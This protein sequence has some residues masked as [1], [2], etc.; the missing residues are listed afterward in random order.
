MCSKNKYRITQTLLSNWL[1]VY[2]TD[3]GYEKFIKCLNRIKE[4]PTQQMLDG[5]QFENCVNSVLDGALIPD[6]HKWYKPVIEI[7][8]FLDRSQKQ[9]NL[10]KDITV[11]G[12][13]FLLHGV[14]DF[15]KAGII[16]DTKFSKTYKVGNYR[17]SPQTPMYFS[18]VPEAYKFIYVICDGKYIYKE[19]YS[20]DDVIPIE[21]MI[22]DFMRFLD[23]YNLVDTYCEKWKVR[24]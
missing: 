12:V 10:F 1:F 11:D 14:L 3:N 24:N 6:D 18:L 20:R 2:K 22:K 13:P 17:E 23:Q 5:I 8:N 21:Q 9:V 15:L 4:K 16:Y 19:S 7:T